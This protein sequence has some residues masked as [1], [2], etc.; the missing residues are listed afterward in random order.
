MDEGDK[1]DSPK[2]VSTHPHDDHLWG[3]SDALSV[4]QRLFASGVMT[5]RTDVNGTITCVSDGKNVRFVCS[6]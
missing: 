1:T 3:L 5:Y 6:K 2:K 4:L